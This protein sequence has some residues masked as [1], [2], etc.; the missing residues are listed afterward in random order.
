[1][2]LVRASDHDRPQVAL[3]GIGAAPMTAQQLDIFDALPSAP[4]EGEAKAVVDSVAE[5]WR[6]A[7]DWRQFVVA[8]EM[9][10][11]ASED[12]ETVHVG[13]VRRL[14]TN[15]HGL[16]IYSR[17]LSAFYSKATG[18]GGFLDFSHWETSDDVAG[19]NQ[20]KPAR[21]Y[22]LRSAA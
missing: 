5:D 13:A 19:R 22:R 11:V 16:T 4:I 7:E 18:K 14:L 21:V 2:R 17:R 1:M 15:E 10:A 3:V 12:G 20:G 6:A 8:V 9:A